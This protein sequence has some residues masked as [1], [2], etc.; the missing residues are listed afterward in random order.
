VLAQPRFHPP[1]SIDELISPQ[2]CAA[3]DR[4]DLTSR[5]LFAGKLQGE[6]RSKARGRSVEFED[7]RQYVPGDDLRHV[8]WNV[9]AR[10]D[11]F[12]IKIFLEEQDLALHVAIDASASM[13]AGGA[14]GGAG[15]KLLQ[16]MRIAMA[17]GYIGLVNNNRVVVWAFDERGVRFL[18]PTRG[19]TGVQKVA[20][21][22]L[23]DAIVRD[24][25]APDRAA[26]SAAD[27]PRAHTFTSAMRTIAQTRTGK[28]VFILLSDLMIPEGYQPGLSL[29]SGAWDTTVMQVLAPGEI[30]PAS[31]LDG[32]GE[33]VVLGDLRLMDVETGRA[34]EVTVNAE[35][36]ARYA[37]RFNAYQD[38]LKAFLTARGMTH[39]LVRSDADVAALLLGDLRRRGVL[40]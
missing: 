8:D 28:G 2:L 30:D 4:L 35:L 21:F 11:R 17:L 19:R 26:A 22:L 7:Y 37:A 31:E 9:F 6:R 14:A 24:A 13:N 36:L 12:F 29:L 3:L 18:P 40:R 38:E 27:R 20:N 5:R 33:R 39:V 23:E 10:L 15:N 34:A 16:A 32:S 25:A 1:Q